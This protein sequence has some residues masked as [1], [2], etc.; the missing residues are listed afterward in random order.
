MT[1]VGDFAGM[2][3]VANGGKVVDQ[4]RIYIHT[5]VGGYSKVEGQRKNIPPGSICRYTAWL[6]CMPMD[7]ALL[8]AAFRKLFDVLSAMG[9]SRDWSV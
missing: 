1:L 2:T 6:H 4:P 9:Y 5:T 3:V 7:S 8:A